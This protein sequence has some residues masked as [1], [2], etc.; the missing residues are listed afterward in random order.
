MKKQIKNMNAFEDHTF[1]TNKRDLAA[2][3]LKQAALDLRRFHGAA[4]AVERELYVDAHR[5]VLSDDCSWPFSFL[6]V[7][8]LLNQRPDD[9]REELLEGLSLGFFSQ[10]AG[11]GTRSLR[12]FSNSLT[13]SMAIRLTGVQL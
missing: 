6:N 9:V 5:W 12:R 13:Q 8:R 11:R 7:C 10:L 1:E 4:S 3:I 2:E